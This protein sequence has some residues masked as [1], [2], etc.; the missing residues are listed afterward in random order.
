MIILRLGENIERRNI[1]SKNM[2]NNYISL[3]LKEISEIMDYVY[4]DFFGD[5]KNIR[6]LNIEEEEMR[7]FFYKNIKVFAES[8]NLFFIDENKLNSATEEKLIREILKV[9]GQV[10]DV[11]NTKAEDKTIKDE[12]DNPFFFIEYY[13]KK[14][15]EGAWKE[16]MRIKDKDFRDHEVLGAFIW[17]AGF[18]KNKL[19]L[20]D[21]LMILGKS[22]EE[23]TKIDIYDE[24]EKI[25]LRLK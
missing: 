22:R 8:P 17:K 10:F 3:G 4:L 9:E 23:N 13:I 19:L 12:N 24:L 1:A 14:D 18:I 25:V 6:I 5:K 7:D 16:L 2:P 20:E 21:L 11:R 15:K